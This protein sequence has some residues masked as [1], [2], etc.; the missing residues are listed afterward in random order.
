[1]VAIVLVIETKSLLLGESASPADVA[2]IA[3]QLVGGG[4]ERVI[5]LRTMHLGPEE[6]LVA[7]K[8]AMPARGEPGA[9]SPPAIDAA[10]VRVRA[11][12]P[13]ARVIYLE[14]DLDRGVS[15]VPI[16]C[17]GARRC[18][19]SR[20]PGRRRPQLRVGF[21]DADPGP[22]RRRARREPGGRTLARARTPTT[23]PACRRATPP[24]TCSSSR[25][26]SALLG[27]DVIAHF[28]ERLPFLVKLL[29]AE[30]SL[31]IQVHPTIAQA[32]AGFAAEDDA[33]VPRDAPN[34]NYRDD[35]HKPE[36]ICALTPFEALCGFR[37]VARH[38][39]TAR[40]A[41]GARA[42]RGAG[43]CWPRRAACGPRSAIC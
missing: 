14:P 34:R 31:S 24:S 9:R 39:A 11:A 35:N 6:V 16:G 13:S 4:I 36:L 5:H 29:A 15:P 30:T 2:A 40:R 38:A 1:M 3:E 18:A 33:G 8:V 22:A 12:V 23:R 28:G 41:G 10:E 7:A 27:R 32:Q 21:A 43:H 25:T 37:P 26:P 17:P 20:R 19:R 42:R